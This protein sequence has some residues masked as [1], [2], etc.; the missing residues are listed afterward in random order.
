VI[1]GPSGI[2]IA[3]FVDDKPG[4]LSRYGLDRPW[5]EVRVSD[6]A[7]TIG[8]LFGGDMTPE[9][10]YFMIRGRPGLYS[11][12]KSLLAFMDQKP[13]DMV[14]RF[15]FIVSI[16]DV[17]RIDFTAGGKTHVMTMSRA[18]KKAETEGQE[19]EI[20]TTFTLDG[21]V[22]ED[23][24][25]RKLYQS[26]IGVQIAGEAP[27][28]SAAAPEIIERFILNKGS[29]REVRV[30]FA[31]YD[32]DFYTVTLNGKTEFVAERGM[33]APV[34]QK[35]DILLNGGTIEN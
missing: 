8:F 1:R 23:S 28:A 7:N 13:L 19:D 21:K 15:A 2:A 33:L 4:D 6:K 30:A 20:V 31:P 22:V 35:L 26:L 9:K 29:E 27:K 18:A 5:G 14:E 32:R 10:V 12:E 24:S 11:V 34:L 25:F 3:D 16:D 17:D